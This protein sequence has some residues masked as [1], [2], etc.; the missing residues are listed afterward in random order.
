MI[1]I[2]V[3]SPTDWSQ[4]AGC[5]SLT[6]IHRAVGDKR[7]LITKA[8]ICL[9]VQADSDSLHVMLLSL[10]HGR[11]PCQTNCRTDVKC[12]H[13]A[14]GLIPQC[15]FGVP[16]TYHDKSKITLYYWVQLGPMSCSA[17]NHNYTFSF[18]KKNY[19]YTSEAVQLKAPIYSRQ[20]LFWV[21]RL[22]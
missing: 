18:L 10:L 13:M 7:A 21:Y 14:H 5:P 20:V 12:L 8:D 15:H 1:I 3:L 17:N 2:G 4:P 16:Q 11:K 6:K 19:A 9:R 22:L